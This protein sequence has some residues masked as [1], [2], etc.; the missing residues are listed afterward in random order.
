MPFADVWDHT[1]LAH[2]ET[3]CPGVC[4]FWWTSF[5]SS[6]LLEARGP[7]HLLSFRSVVLT[8]GKDCACRAVVVFG[9][10]A[11]KESVMSTSWFGT[12]PHSFFLLALTVF[13]FVSSL[14]PLVEIRAVKMSGSQRSSYWICI[15][16]CSRGLSM[17]NCKV[18]RVTES[19]G[20]LQF[21][22]M[23]KKL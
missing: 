17:W 1:A 13:L 16:V 5:W 10:S 4:V 9:M 6:G 23:V 3:S 22:F 7:L 21:L 15:M 12:E 18:G 20:M 8:S 14:N 11:P 2:C 19:S